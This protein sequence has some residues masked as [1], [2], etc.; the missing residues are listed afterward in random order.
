VSDEV[1]QLLT[2]RRPLG[3]LDYDNMR[4]AVADL[5]SLP[6]SANER[7]ISD[8]GLSGAQRR[9]SMLLPRCRRRW[10]RVEC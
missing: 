4:P 3:S 1:S 10:P 2:C 6:P 7:R 5:L 8:G 9:R